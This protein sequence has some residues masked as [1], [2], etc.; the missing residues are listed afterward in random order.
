MSSLGTRTQA[1]HTNGLLPRGT[2]TRKSHMNPGLSKRISSTFTFAASGA[3]VTG[4][5]N[6]FASFVAGEPVVFKGT[7]LN[8]AEYMVTGI[9]ATNH[10][11]LV[12]A[13]PPKDEASIAAVARTP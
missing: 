5:T 7:N 1:N 12:L 10:A 2:F 3:T 4:S 8:D 11:Y 13:P 6:D 9:D